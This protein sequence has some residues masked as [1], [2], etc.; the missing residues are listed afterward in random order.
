ML[1]DFGITGTNTGMWGLEVVGRVG[2]THT[3]RVLG[4]RTLQ[5]NLYRSALAEIRPERN[6]K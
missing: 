1:G 4:V 2:A 6:V 5:W 3:G